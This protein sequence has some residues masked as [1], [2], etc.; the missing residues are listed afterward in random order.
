MFRFLG[1]TLIFSI[2]VQQFQVF[3]G[4]LE[5]CY[6]PVGGILIADTTSLFM[7]K[8]DTRHFDTLKQI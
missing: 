5:L 3:L 1:I 6:S 2:L 7:I 4:L 8:I